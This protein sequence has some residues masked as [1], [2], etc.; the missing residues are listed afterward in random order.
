MEEMREDKGKSGWGKKNTEKG[1]EVKN[2]TERVEGLLFEE[3]L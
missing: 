1:R 2:E 3:L